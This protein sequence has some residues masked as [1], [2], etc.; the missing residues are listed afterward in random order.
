[1]LNILKNWKNQQ[2]AA[3]NLERYTKE[4][5]LKGEIPAHIAI[6]MDGNGRWA[7]KRALPR[8][9]GHHEGMKVVKRTTKLANELGVK[10][11]SLYAFSTENWKRPK[12]EVDFLMKL[13]EEFLNTYLPELVE[14]NVRVQIMGDQSTLPDHTF[15][16]MEKAVRDT[17]Q[18]DGLILNFALNYGG[19]TEI[20]CAAKSLAEKVKD[21]S[22]NVEDIDE[23]LFSDYL[24]TESLQDPELLIR[25]SGEIRLSNFMLWQVAYSEFVFTDVL[26]PDFKENDFLKALGEFQQ[27]G[28]RFGGI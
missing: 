15:R 2:T 28:R 3:S 5:I 26:W 25:T 6:I 22:L 10:V 23:S 8:I 19:R 24:M 14:E 20:V 7:K 21:G 4:D 11:L 18:N 13:P 1:M 17:E 9:A 12:P 27:R 16:A